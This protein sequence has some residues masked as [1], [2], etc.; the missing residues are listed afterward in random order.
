MNRTVRPTEAASSTAADEDSPTELAQGL[1]VACKS[2]TPTDRYETALVEATGDDLRRVREERRTALAFWI[3]CYNAGTQ[4]LLDERPDLYESRLRFVR[5]FHA[6]AI[7]V[8]DTALALDRIENGLLRGGRSKYGLGYLPRI[9]VTSFERRYRLPE[10]DPRIHFALN[11]GAAAC[12]PIAAYSAE[13]IDRELDV[14]TES[15][16]GSEVE[17]D[18]EAGRAEVPRLLLWFRGDFGGRSGIY[19]LLREHGPV[20][21]DARPS[22]S[23]RSYDWSLELGKFADEPVE[24]PSP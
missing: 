2:G 15:Y 5:F 19:R 13:G 14:A 3:N 12:P 8:A 21:G 22:V 24:P 9:V 20:P 4:L 1:L 16:L 18:P 17:Y 10:C 23:Y 7:T 6:P 11:C